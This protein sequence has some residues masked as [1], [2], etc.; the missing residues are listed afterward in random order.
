M[1]F[2]TYYITHTFVNAIKKIFKTWVIILL[3]VFIIFGFAGGIL[4]VFLSKSAEKNTENY[5]EVVVEETVEGED[6][7]DFDVDKMFKFIEIAVGYGIILVIAYNIYVGSKNGASIFTMPDVN[8]LFASPLKPQSVLFFRLILQM[9]LILFSSIYFLFQIPN[10]INSAK[11][12]VLQG[13]FLYLSWIFLIVFAKLISVFTYTI[14]NTKEKLKKYIIPFIIVF[15]AITSILN[16]YNLR[17]FRV[18]PV[19][20]SLKGF[21]M[22]NLE[23]DLKGFVLSLTSIIITVLILFY[24]IYKIKADFYEDAFN[25]AVV[26]QKKIEAIAEGKNKIVKRKIKK[27]ETYEIGRGEGANMFFFKA[28]YNIKRSAKIGYFSS[29]SIVAVVVIGIVS[30][31]MKN[32]LSINNINFIAGIIIYFIFI[33]NNSNPIAQ[34]VDKSF[35]YLVPEKPF[36]KL[37]YT[38]LGSVV[39]NALN[40]IPGF[41]LA[42]YILKTDFLTSLSWIVV[43][44]TLDLLSSAIGFIFEM[45]ISS[46]IAIMVKSIIKI[47]V[48]MIFVGPLLIFILIFS[49]VFSL[50]IGLI[51]ASIFNFIVSISIFLLSARLLHTGKN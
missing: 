3:M 21:V 40:V 42:T 11:L 33:M 13:A 41:L 8:F 5:N 16:M 27:V 28:L 29:T 15:T 9:G 4:G 49:S 34:E 43:F 31:I 23:G 51:M 19:L 2:F 6:E 20:G 14:I 39:E 38:I 30:L 10:I 44:I 36:K 1:S 32:L 45:I 17:W 18:I 35:I 7:D 25:S 22:Y 47:F 50:E 37:A 48:K 46:G 12:S 26:K 24:I